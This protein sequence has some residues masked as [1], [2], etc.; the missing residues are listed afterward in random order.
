VSRRP[1]LIVEFGAKGFEGHDKICRC[2]HDKRDTA[3][4]GQPAPLGKADHALRHQAQVEQ[5]EG[6]EGEAEARFVEEVVKRHPNAGGKPCLI[7][8]CQAGWQIMMM[9]AIDSERVGPIILAGSPLSYWAGVHGK[10]PMRY[11]GGLLGGT[12][13]TSLAGD[14][15]NGI[16]RRRM[17]EREAAKAA[18]ECAI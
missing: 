11:L 1:A 5:Y 13:L 17:A 15:G 16:F 6:R 4:T 10:N 12:W 8:N 18:E 3:P 9:A 2:R 7:G 14:L